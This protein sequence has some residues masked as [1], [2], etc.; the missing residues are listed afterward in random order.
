[1]SPTP[2][3]EPDIPAVEIAESPMPE[4]IVLSI[5]PDIDEP[6][7]LPPRTSD[8]PATDVRAIAEQAF[9]GILDALRNQLTVGHIGVCPACD[10]PF[11]HDQA[12]TL[13]PLGPGADPGTR[14]RARRGDTYSARAIPVH[15]A[16]ATGQTS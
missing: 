14:E 15:R 7:A 3:I 16:C 4:P 5:T 2:D 8:V 12:V 6:E 11:H 1:V 13:V 9:T 10:Q